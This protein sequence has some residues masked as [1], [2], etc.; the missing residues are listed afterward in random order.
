MGDRMNSMI[1]KITLLSFSLLMTAGCGRPSKLPVSDSSL[2]TN[3]KTIGYDVLKTQIFQPKCISCH[4]NFA[5]YSG[6][7]ASGVVIPRNPTGSLLHSKCASGQMPKGGSPLSAEEVTA[8]YEWISAGAVE[9]STTPVAGPIPAPAP[10][11]PAPAPGSI[12][13]TYAWINANV[14]VQRCVICHQGAGAPAGY[15]LSSFQ[16]V[17]AGGRV[18]PGNPGASVLYQRINN[19]SMPPG[20]PALTAEVKQA[21]ATWIQNGA[22]NDA[23]LGGVTPPPPLPPLE[24]KFASLMANV[25]GPRCVGCHGSVNPRAGINLSTY[26]AVLR[27]VRPGDANGSDLYRV[28]DSNDMPASGGPLSFVQ[29]ENLRQWINGGALNN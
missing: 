29:K 19:N 5:T 3:G 13:P 25:F 7:M 17:G 15:D 1:S 16:S 10:A 12:S 18:M 27:R 21:I 6:L 28:I 24:P 20:G 4:S 26:A 2:L 8:I 23:P 14:F 9:F 11:P 22:L